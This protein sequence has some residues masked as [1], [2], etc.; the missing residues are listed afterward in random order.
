MKADTEMTVCNCSVNHC[1]NSVNA[2]G[3]NEKNLPHVFT[4]YY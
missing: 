3:I 2:V 4:E 1:E